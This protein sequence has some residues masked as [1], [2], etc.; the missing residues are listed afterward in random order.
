MHERTWKKGRE[1]NL[2]VPEMKPDLKIKMV[3][4]RIDANFIQERN[5]LEKCN[6]H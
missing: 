3:R 5:K 6:D 4:I 2:Q 1:K